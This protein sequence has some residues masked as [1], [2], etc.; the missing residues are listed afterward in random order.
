MKIG[1]PLSVQYCL[2][3]DPLM[4]YCCQSLN[5]AGCPLG[6]PGLLG[7]LPAL[8]IPPPRILAQVPPSRF[9]PIFLQRIRNNNINEY[10]PSSI[11]LISWHIK[12]WIWFKRS[13]ISFY[14]ITDSTFSWEQLLLSFV[15]SFWRI[16]EIMLQSVKEGK[17]DWTER[18]REYQYTVP[19]ASHE[20]LQ[21]TETQPIVPPTQPTQHRT[22]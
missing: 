10:G 12:F 2:L 5:V 7:S 21:K 13:H 8:R 14:H 20:L 3:C 18:E 16:W 4:F 11:Y 15:I 19:A 1:F 22:N 17:E 9:P 6:I